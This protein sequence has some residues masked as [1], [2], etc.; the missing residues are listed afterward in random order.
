MT[1]SFRPKTENRSHI[2]QVFDSVMEK[3][4]TLPYPGLELTTRTDIMVLEIPVPK[5]TK[6]RYTFE[7]KVEEDE[8]M[9][10]RVKHRK[11][12]AFFLRAHHLFCLELDNV[13]YLDLKRIRHWI[14]II[15]MAYSL[16]VSQGIEY[17]KECE[18]FDV[19]SKV[20]DTITR[21]GKPI[22]VSENPPDTLYGLIERKNIEYAIKVSYNTDKE[23]Q[24]DPT[25]EVRM[26]N[27]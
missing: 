11:E 25:Q 15:R 20:H 16:Q 3:S 13:R 22:F 4:F 5:D 1:G 6:Y 26:E 18:I 27:G 7:K 17:K 19:F 23:F 10:M 24:P 21:T 14:P 8:K 2:E 12:L 9:A